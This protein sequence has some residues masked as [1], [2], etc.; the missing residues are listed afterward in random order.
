[1]DQYTR[2]ARLKPAM[3]VALPIGLSTLTL[4]PD[5]AAAWTV[6][7]GI[8]S[9]CGGTALLT[10]VGRDPGRSKENKLFNLWDGKPTTRMLRHRDAQN[11][12]LLNGYHKKLQNLLP[13][14]KI[15]TAEEEKVDPSMADQVYDRCVSYLR[16]KTRNRT[17]FPLV[18]EENCNYGFRRNLWGMK[19]MGL[20]LATLGAVVVCG[21]LYVNYR[22]TQTLTP[23]LA[24]VSGIGNLLLVYGWVF[25]ITP[26]WVKITADAYAERL[27]AASDEM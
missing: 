19:P 4:F 24:V 6:V 12:A 10:Q 23:P 8:A 20:A 2:R 26:S 9:L 27:L 5:G 18:F 15:P 16:E 14:I 13:D 11:Q 1:M 25:L 22:A 7:W 3:L 17:V 21:L